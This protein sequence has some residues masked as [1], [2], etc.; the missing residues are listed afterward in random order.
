MK[1]ICRALANY[2][3]NME[4]VI[5]NKKEKKELEVTEKEKWKQ[6]KLSAFW[7]KNL[8][9]QGEVNKCHFWLHCS[10]L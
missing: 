9:D 2:I 4:K 3:E 1:N 5:F 6:L 8:E 7:G 10:L